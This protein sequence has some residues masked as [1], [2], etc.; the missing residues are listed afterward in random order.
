MVKNLSYN[1]WDTG[2]IPGQIPHA[3]EQLS[4]QA[5]STKP[6]HSGACVSQLE[7]STTAPTCQTQS[8]Q[9][10]MK[11]PMYRNSESRDPNK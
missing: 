3:V 10:T 9:A 6:V 7:S 2:L 5:A 8:L 11:D 1:A 4:F